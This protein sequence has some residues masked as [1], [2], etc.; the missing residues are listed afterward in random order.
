MLYLEMNQ[1]SL[2][3]IEIDPLRDASLKTSFPG[4]FPLPDLPSPNAMGAT[5]DI[6][7]STRPVAS[8]GR[9]RPCGSPQTL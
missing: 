9:M 8:L 6:P 1:H 7:A 5:L 2:I 3:L 4:T